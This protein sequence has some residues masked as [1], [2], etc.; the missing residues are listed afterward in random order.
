MCVCVYV[1]TNICLRMKEPIYMVSVLNEALKAKDRHKK[2]YI[3]L[4]IMMKRTVH[5]KT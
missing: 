2:I 5:L 1:W 4:E 3:C